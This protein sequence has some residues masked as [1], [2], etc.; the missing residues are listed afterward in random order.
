MDEVGCMKPSIDCLRISSPGSLHVL[1]DRVLSGELQG[2]INTAL[3]KNRPLS[4]ES[5]ELWQVQVDKTRFFELYEDN[6]LALEEMTPHQREKLR[7][8]R[9]MSSVHLS[10]PAGAG[11]TFVAV[12]RVLEVLMEDNG[13]RVLYVAPSREL[14]YHFLQW[15]VMRL[16][17]QFPDPMNAT[18]QQLLSHMVVMHKPYRS[19][20]T[21]KID[22]DSIEFEEAE[23]L[24]CC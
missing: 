18:I 2:Q 4:N 23:N 19:L 11:K 13:H 16:L 17:V 15:M 9:G 3:S 20:R 12:Q 1:R 10:A 8:I 21:P 22:D 14:V 24:G 6:L 5:D 7:D